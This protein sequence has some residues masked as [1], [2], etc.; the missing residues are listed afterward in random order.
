MTHSPLKKFPLALIKKLLPPML[1]LR[2]I[3]RIYGE[4]RKNRFLFRQTFQNVS[5]LC[6][7]NLNPDYLLLE[8][9]P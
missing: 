8:N 5:F 1:R 3:S 9:L 2:G 4:I 6:T 7:F